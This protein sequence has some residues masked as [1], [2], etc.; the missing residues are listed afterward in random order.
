MLD[1][2]KHKLESRLLGEI[3]ITSD[4]QMTPP[5]HGASPTVRQL[6]GMEDQGR[7]RKACVKERLEKNS[8]DKVDLF[9][10]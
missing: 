3:S 1:W 10:F 8:E 7:P 9:L 4:M 6:P 2:E 5:S